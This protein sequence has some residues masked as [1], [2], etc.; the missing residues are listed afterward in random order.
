MSQYAIALVI[1]EHHFCDLAIGCICRHRASLTLLLYS[2]LGYCEARHI[3]GLQPVDGGDENRIPYSDANQNLI[4]E[5]NKNKK[6]D[7]NGNN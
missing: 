5:D 2:L 4:G 1:R 6:E 7:E 3:I